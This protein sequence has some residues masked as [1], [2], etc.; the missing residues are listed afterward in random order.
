VGDEVSRIRTVKPEMFTDAKLA[1]CSIPARHTFTGLLTES[2]DYARQLYTA[3]RVTAAVF[4]HDGFNP[5]KVDAWVREL[6]SEGIIHFYDAQGNTHLCIPNFHKHQKVS[7]RTPS[8]LPP[9]PTHG[10]IWAAPELPQESPGESGEAQGSPPLELGTRKLEVGTEELTGSSNPGKPGREAKEIA[11][12]LKKR[13]RDRGVTAFAQDWHLTATS[14][15]DWLLRSGTAGATIVATIDWA[16][17]D[18]FYATRVTR[19]EKVRDLIPQYQQQAAGIVGK[20]SPHRLGTL[21]RLEFELQ[22]AENGQSA[23][24]EAGKQT[25]G[26]LPG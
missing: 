9:C 22:E 4:P 10:D 16:L 20:P 14:V 1:R 3:V 7:K 6:E 24:D 13:L 5:R 19:M 26:S 12:Y 25:R 2:D 23:S 11:A 8:R 17:D 15:A 21:D 18:E